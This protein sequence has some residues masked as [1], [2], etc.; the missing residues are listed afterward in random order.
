MAS[1]FSIT[2]G[3]EICELVLKDVENFGLN[4]PRMSSITTVGVPFMIDGANKFT[5]EFL[6]AIGA[7]DL[8]Q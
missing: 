3:Q 5:N 6:A 1:L 7:K 8:I 2:T 4:P